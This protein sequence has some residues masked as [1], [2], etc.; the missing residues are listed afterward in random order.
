MAAATENII[1][2]IVAGLPVCGVEL[3]NVGW[4]SSLYP[5]KINYR[6]AHQELLIIICALENDGDTRTLHSYIYLSIYI[7][8]YIISPS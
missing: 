1:H 8:L 7:Y 2:Q 5:P 4:S 3:A 6:T